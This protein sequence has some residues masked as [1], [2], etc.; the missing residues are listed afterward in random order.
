MSAPGT[1]RWAAIGPPGNPKKDVSMVTA[2][3]RRTAGRNTKETHRKKR[4]FGLDPLSRGAEGTLLASAFDDPG[5]V[6]IELTG[7]EY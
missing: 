1:Q 5:Y 6:E 7:S 3:L 2:C 4:A